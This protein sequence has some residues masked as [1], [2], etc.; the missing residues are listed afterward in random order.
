MNVGR[1]LIGSLV[2]FVFIFL[3]EY[4]FH[5]I[6][7]SGWYEQQ[8][9]LLR[10]E[11]E[12]NAYFIWMIL[13]YLILSFGFCFVFLKGYEN[14]GCGEGIRYGLY[15]G[16]AFI[17]STNLI[18]YAVIPYPGKWIVAWNIGY[19]IIMMLA[20]MIFAMIYRPATSK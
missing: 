7:L 1:Y 12:A 19:P 13:G 10:P 5:G 11:A 4:V 3:I 2:V 9:Q 15:V 18:N 16:I 17:V 6:L 14:K 8:M 20:G